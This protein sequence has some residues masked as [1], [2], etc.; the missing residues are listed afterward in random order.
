MTSPVQS[1]SSLG[2]ARLSRSVGT[3]QLDDTYGTRHAPNSGNFQLCRNQMIS[4]ASSAAWVNQLAPPQPATRVLPQRKGRHRAGRRTTS[5]RQAALHPDK[6]ARPSWRNRRS[7]SPF[8]EGV[9][10]ILDAEAAWR[11]GHLP[12]TAAVADWF[13]SWAEADCS[14]RYQFNGESSHL[15]RSCDRSRSAPAPG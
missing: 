1:R 13:S 5:T 15:R 2:L 11:A 14:Y 10:L 12:P 3:S 8:L 7:S 9:D 4:R 6:P